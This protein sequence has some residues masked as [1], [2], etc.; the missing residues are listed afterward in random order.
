MQIT[1]KGVTK[2]VIGSFVV[3]QLAACG[4]LIY[5]ERNGQKGGKLDL[6]V[7]ALDAVGLLLWFVPGVIAFG[8][9]FVTG[10]IYLPGGSV[11]QLSDE[12]MQKLK[13]PDGQL[14]QVALQDWLIS[15]DY[16]DSSEI[17]GQQLMTQAYQTPD[18]LKRAVGMASTERYAKLSTLN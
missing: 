14:D 6:G 12:D 3:S 2:L 5:P 9:D 16:L 1:T 8:V 7:V 4:T 11:A 17:E 18:E 13:T 10:A 15:N